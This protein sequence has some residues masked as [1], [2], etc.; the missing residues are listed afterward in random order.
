[1]RMTL[2]RPALRAA[3]AAFPDG[4]ALLRTRDPAL[5]T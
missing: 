2:L 3:R 5:D 4:P 1:M